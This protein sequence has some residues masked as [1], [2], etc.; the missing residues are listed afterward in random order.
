M[1]RHSFQCYCHSILSHGGL[2][3]VL[4]TTHSL[5]LN[6]PVAQYTNP[7]PAHSDHD[8]SPFS[9]DMFL[10]SRKKG[11]IGYAKLITHWIVPLFSFTVNTSLSQLRH[12][13]PDACYHPSESICIPTNLNRVSPQHK[14]PMLNSGST[15]SH[16][17]YVVFFCPS[18]LCES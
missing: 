11:L 14:P 13:V 18:D 9:I 15:N 4:V 7:S 3:Y 16:L 12:R 1:R 2:F 10:S 17:L 8:N 6:D 5:R